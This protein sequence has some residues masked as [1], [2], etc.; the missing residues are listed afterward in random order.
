[1]KSTVILLVGALVFASMSTRFLPQN[2]SAQQGVGDEDEEVSESDL[3]LYIQVY[4]DMQANHGLT[5]EDALK[6]HNVSLEQFRAIERRIQKQQRYVDRVRKALLEYAR[7]Q[8]ATGTLP[9][10]GDGQEPAGK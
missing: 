4:K 2:H 9:P 8:A 6:S 7:S 3:E 5:I 10:E 1:M